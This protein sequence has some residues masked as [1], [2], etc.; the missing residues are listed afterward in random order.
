MGP[1][2]RGQGGGVPLASH[3]DQSRSAR[4][5]EDFTPAT[6]AAREL[7][8]L[9]RKVHE[10]FRRGVLDDIGTDDGRLRQ[11]DDEPSDS[12]ASELTVL[13]LDA[14]KAD[15]DKYDWFDFRPNVLKLILAGAAET[16]HIAI[17]W[18]TVEDGAVGLHYHS[19]TESVYVIDG[20]QTDAKDTYPTGTVYF[21]PPG[22]GHEISD[23]SGF[24]L[25]ALCGPPDFMATDSIEEYEPIRIDTEDEDL[26]TE[27]PFEEAAADVSKFEVPLD[28]AG[29]M[30]AELIETSS[31]DDYAFTGNYVLVLEGSCEVDG[32]TYAE[33]MLVVTKDVEPH[34]VHRRR[35]A[36]QHLPRPRRLV[37]IRSACASRAPL[38]SRARRNDPALPVEAASPIQL[39]G[40][41][42]PKGFGVVA[43]LRA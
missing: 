35:H 17:L 30:S 25:L 12:G 14:L 7:R 13:D 26:T 6:R 16:E 2:P 38:R 33:D 15:P 8:H 19:K 22:S 23:S 24:F 4:G 40:E 32:E 18:Y 28:A 27:Y 21:N 9:E 37:L 34:A 11:F 31:G 3:W 10:P 29:G 1:G 41:R 36:R 5:H 43:D 20:T 39:P 42:F